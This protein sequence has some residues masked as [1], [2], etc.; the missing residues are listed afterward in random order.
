M[1][2]L[3]RQFLFSLDAERAHHLATFA[4]RV[5][6]TIS[7][8][9][10][11]RRF[12]FES[13]RLAIDVLGLHFDNP[14]GLAA[15][16][17]KNAVL[18]PFWRLTGMGF[19]E[20]GSV[21][22]RKCQGN[23]RPRSFRL[24]LDEALVNRMGLNNQGADRIARRVGQLDRSRPLAINLVKTHD[25][26]I[27]GQAAVDDFVASFARLAPL[28]SFVVLNLSCPNTAEGKTFEDPNTL[29]DLLAAIMS[30]RAKVAPGVPV[31]LKLS[32]PES[33]RI[34]LDSAVDEIVAVGASH[35]VAGYVASNTAA[36]R[37]GVT[38]PED[39][40][41]R[42]GPGGLSGRPIE[43]RATRLVRYLFRRTD[44]RVPV[45][46]VGGVFTAEDAYR[47]IRAGASLVELYTGL[48]YEGPG[49]VRRL[50]EGLVDLLD[51]DRLER[52]EDAVGLD[53]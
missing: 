28:A 4:G 6:Q 38:T 40:L 9:T 42:I 22:A 36:D 20:I 39:Q 46:G 31:L 49:L 43:R 2:H 12:S 29:D 25:A 17:D 14:I 53:A 26:S 52:I 47:K 32:P 10:L 48:V 37:N 3:A 19:T 15:G 24:P 7:R 41:E 23:R 45:I 5:G 35:G 51:R 16:M 44:G 30:E 8:S 34:V 13:E 18:V 21:S 11:E 1:Y 27:A 33:E 50:K